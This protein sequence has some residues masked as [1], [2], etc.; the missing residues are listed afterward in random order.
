MYL[1]TILIITFIHNV[2]SNYIQC[3]CY[4]LYIATAILDG[5]TQTWKDAEALC[6]SR[7]NTHLA[8]IH[9]ETDNKE[10]QEIC[11]KE[12]GNN[13]IGP[14][15]WIGLKHVGDVRTDDPFVIVK[16]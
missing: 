13:D 12:I 6:L 15:C 9:S 1:L 5:S 4:I 14:F 10:I 2:Y 7:Y 3:S 16:T 8:S 11:T